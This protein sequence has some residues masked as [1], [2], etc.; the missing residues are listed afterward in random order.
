M[1][2]RCCCSLPGLLGLGW[3][4]RSGLVV[5]SVP[6]GLADGGCLGA[7]VQQ[8]GRLFLRLVSVLVMLT[9]QACSARCGLLCLVLRLPFPGIQCFAPGLAVRCQFLLEPRVPLAVGFVARCLA[10]RIPLE[11][12]ALLPVREPL[13]LGVILWWLT[14]RES[15]PRLVFFAVLGVRLA[16]AFA[17]TLEPPGLGV[18]G[19]YLVCQVPQ[20]GLA[21]FGLWLCCGRSLRCHE[22]VLCVPLVW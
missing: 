17:E 22:G 6:G 3:I 9:G 20:P 12:V 16:V 19:G 4:G 1:A 2:L 18:V 5:R 7:V 11:R 14:L 21:L 10:L 13:D 15:L 8:V